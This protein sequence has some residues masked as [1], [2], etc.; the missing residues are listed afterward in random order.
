MSARVLPFPFPFSVGT[1]ICHVK[2]IYNML[3]AKKGPRLV[4][5]ILSEEEIA[6]SRVDL[7]QIMDANSALIKAARL[8]KADKN[9]P[10][11]PQERPQSAAARER[12]GNK[13]A[14][15]KETASEVYI[16][17]GKLMEAAKYLAGR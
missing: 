14:G 16:A 13:A 5:R 11:T 1:D 4:R 15:E 3:F 12:G 7:T 6:R 9:E 2:R 8:S 17:R 10:T